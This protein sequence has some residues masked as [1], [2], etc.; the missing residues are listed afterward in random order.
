MRIPLK[1]IENPIKFRSYVREA[2]EIGT[3]LKMNKI[4]KKK[5]KFQENKIH[6]R[7]K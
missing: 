7:R 2:K 6:I 5:K 4:K 1:E 3:S